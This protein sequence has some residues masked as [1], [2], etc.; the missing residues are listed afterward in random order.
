M[1]KRLKFLQLSDVHLDSPLSGGRLGLPKDKVAQLYQA[2]GKIQVKHKIETCPVC[3]G[4]GYLGQTGVF[5]TMIVGD[6]TRRMIMASD[7]KAAMADARRNKMIYLQEAALR[8]VV[9]GETTIEEVVRVLTPARKATTQP[10]PDPAA[11]T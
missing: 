7:L 9:D 4:T 2:A 1:S 5:Q 6:E 3:E 8:R 10:R 11:A